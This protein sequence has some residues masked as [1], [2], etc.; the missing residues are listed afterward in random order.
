MGKQD[1][2][3]IRENLDKAFLSVL[4]AA[5]EGREAK[6]K[7]SIELVN[8][9]AKVDD[10]DIKIEKNEEGQFVAQATKDG[11]VFHE[12]VYKV[13]SKK[14]ARQVFEAELQDLTRT[15]TMTQV[16]NAKFLNAA[17]QEAGVSVS[18]KDIEGNRTSPDHVEVSFFGEGD[19]QL[20]FKQLPEELQDEVALY[21]KAKGGKVTAKSAA[22]EVPIG[23]MMDDK[24][25]AVDPAPR[26][27]TESEDVLRATV[28][29]VL[30]DKGAR[31]RPYGT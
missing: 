25:Q 19:K 28:K 21:L 6:V 26:T 31:G 5:R 9:R 3:D 1:K 24:G 15:N 10:Y 12:N 2:I 29:R 13:K 11:E 17:A 7:P 4:K 23:K 22:E 8:Q 16:G 14:S 27:D 30:K 18:I 20:S